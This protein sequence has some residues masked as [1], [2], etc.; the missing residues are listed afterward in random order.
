VLGC[1]FLFH[2][3]NG[4]GGKVAEYKIN[5]QKSVACLYTNNEQTKKKYRKIT[6]FTT[7][8]KT[9]TKKKKPRNELN[10]ECE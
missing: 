6:P 1:H 2:V 7:A 9:K 5:L 10:K 8:S 3:Q 4:G